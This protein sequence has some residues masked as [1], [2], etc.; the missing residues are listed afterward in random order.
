M[1]EAGLA[2][3]LGRMFVFACRAPGVRG[4]LPIALD[5]V[6]T[7]EGVV[8]SGL[9]DGSSRRRQGGVGRA[10][11]TLLQRDHRGARSPLGFARPHPRL[12]SFVVAPSTGQP[13][14]EISLAALCGRNISGSPEKTGRLGQVVASGASE[15]V[16]GLAVVA[17]LERGSRCLTPGLSLAV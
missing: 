15:Q 12:D 7:G 11:L 1:N 10:E 4:G 9:L 3:N 17:K 13:L 6:E 16:A 14:G 8:V 5:L 2:E